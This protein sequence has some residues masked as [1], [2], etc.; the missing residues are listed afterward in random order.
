MEHLNI[1]V[2]RRVGGGREAVRWGGADRAGVIRAAQS[3]ADYG[4]NRL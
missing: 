4:E 1:G 3:R 2:V